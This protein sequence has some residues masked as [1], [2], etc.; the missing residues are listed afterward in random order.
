MVVAVEVTGASL[1]QQFVD[2]VVLGAEAGRKLVDVAVGRIL[3]AGSQF[4][5]QTRD[6][7][8]ILALQRGVLGD[9]RSG[10]R[11]LAGFDGDEGPAGEARALGV[12]DAGL[13]L[14]VGERVVAERTLDG[15]EVG[16]GGVDGFRGSPAD[17]ALGGGDG[18]RLLGELGRVGLG[19]AADFFLGHGRAADVA[20]DDQVLLHE[21]EFIAELLGGRRRNRSEGAAGAF[22]DLRS[23]LEVAGIEGIPGG[24]DGARDFFE[25]ALVGGGDFGEGADRGGR[26]DR[27]SRV[28]S[29]R[30]G[31]G[32]FRG[33]L[34][35]GS[36]L[37]GGGDRSEA[38]DGAGILGV[39][40]KKRLV[41]FFRGEEVAF[42]AGFQGF[43]EQHRPSGG[44]VTVLGDKRAGGESEDQGGPGKLLTLE[45]FHEWGL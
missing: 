44:R 16:E 27:G 26:G 9:Q 39:D 29:G 34:G 17:L 45:I 28:R 30:L 22:D 15:V 41:L 35:G 13:E 43:D 8:V 18:G 3:G 24:L 14:L 23:T 1:D 37:E 11:H 20:T 19:E 31:G 40:G 10:L 12:L 36:L 38:F 4:L 21:R 6:A 25:A 2:L 33:L 32:G 42:V 7:R 5:L